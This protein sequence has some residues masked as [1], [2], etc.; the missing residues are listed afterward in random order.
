MHGFTQQKRAGTFKAMLIRP[1][2]WKTNNYTKADGTNNVVTQLWKPLC[3]FIRHWDK[4]VWD[5]ETQY[6]ECQKDLIYLA[7]RRVLEYL[8][9]FCFV[10]S[11]FAFGPKYL[12]PRSQVAK[13]AESR[14][15]WFF[16]VFVQRFFTHVRVSVDRA[17]KGKLEVAL[18][19]G[20]RFLNHGRRSLATTE[21]EKE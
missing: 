4:T 11:S 16:V 17:V 3:V 13:A 6:W 18:V 19:V 5:T 9:G 8:D 1:D 12:S 14:P 2:I 7:N 21:A 10:K 20:G 15:T